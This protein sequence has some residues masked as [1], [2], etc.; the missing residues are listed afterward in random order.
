MISDEMKAVIVAD[1]CWHSTRNLLSTWPPASAP[2]AH[3]LRLEPM[4]WQNAR[5]RGI[6]PWEWG[7]HLEQVT[8]NESLVKAELPPGWMKQ[9]P[10]IGQWPLA[11]ACERWKKSITPKPASTSLWITY[12]HYLALAD[13]IEPQSL[14]YYNLDDYTLYWPAKADQVRDWEARAVA[15][16]DWTVCVAAERAR[17]LRQAFPERADRILHLAHGAPL[18]T[19]PPEPQFEPVPAPAQ[20]AHIPRPWLGYL[21]GLEDRL[22]W[23]LIDRIADRFP[24]ASV[25]LVGPKPT[26]EGPEEWKLLARKTIA[27]PN[28]Y[29]A[30]PV[31]QERIGETYASFDVNLIP[32][33]V[34]HP[35]NIACSP[36]KLMDAMGSGRPTVATD[37]P[38]CRIHD[39]LYRV[40]SSHE[41]FLEELDQLTTARFRDGLEA[42][43]WKYA[44]DHST[45]VILDKLFRLS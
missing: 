19:I 21:G 24:Q 23:R 17:T 35:F 4:D 27:R 18:Q 5:A 10:S 3:L 11:R 8:P 41:R 20:F 9:F 30:G 42:E 37:L 33:D 45:L 16:A 13:Q 36:T 40:A 12:P 31:N 28:V 26:L 15:R 22:D 29:A 32:Y 1:S 39:R 34:N 14:I 7:V 44:R 6:R 2:T 25:V 43:R 38:E